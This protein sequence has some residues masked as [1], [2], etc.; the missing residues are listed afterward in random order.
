M[1]FWVYIGKT[2]RCSQPSTRCRL[3]VEG[4]QRVEEVGHAEAAVAPGL[5][6]AHARGQVVGVVRELR[7]EGAHRV[8]DPGDEGLGGGE[9]VLLG[10]DRAVLRLHRA[11]AA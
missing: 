10:V 2:T 5:E 4:H 9:V 1:P 6:V 7:G 3:G 8:G 11:Q